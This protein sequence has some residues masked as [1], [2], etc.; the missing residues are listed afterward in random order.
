MT[1]AGGQ[2]PRGFKPAAAT[3]AVTPAPGRVAMDVPGGSVLWLVA[4]G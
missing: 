2:R 4:A 1:L 3:P